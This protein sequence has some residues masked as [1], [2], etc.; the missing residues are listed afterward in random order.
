[1]SLEKPPEYLDEFV[2]EDIKRPLSLSTPAKYPKTEASP[3]G[4]TSQQPDFSEVDRLVKKA[5]LDLFLVFA[6]VP[7]EKLPHVSKILY[8]HDITNFGMFLPPDDFTARDVQKLGISWGISKLLFCEAPKYYRHLLEREAAEALNQ[9]ASN[10]S[11]HSGTS[12]DD[13]AEFEYDDF[14]DE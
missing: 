10:E 12:S 9:S 3:P 6:E 4:P 14:E 11:S 5:N 8:E 1:M 7:D 2:W 13:D